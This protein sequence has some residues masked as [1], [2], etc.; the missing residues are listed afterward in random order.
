VGANWLIEQALKEPGGIW[1]VIAPTFRDVRATCFE[2]PSG[3]RKQLQPGE[4]VQWRRN[5]LRLDLVNGSI[6]YGFSADQPERLR[7]TNLSGCWSDEL[8][9]WRY[10]ETWY[11]GL[12]PALRIGKKPRVVITTTPRPTRLIKDLTSRRD[13]TVH[14]TQAATWE[15]A[16]NLSETALSEMRAR[17]EGT[18][19]GRQELE[20]QLLEDLE[21]ALWNRADIDAARIREDQVPDL[22]RIV[23]AIDPAVTNN[24]DSDETGIVVAGDDGNGH[25]YI[26]ADLSMMGTPE[27]CMKTAVAAYHRY[28]A[29]CVVAEVN[30]GGD[31]LGAVLRAADPNVPYHTVRASRGKAIRA[32]PVSALAEQHR[33][34]HVGLFPEL[35]DQMCSLTPG[36]SNGPDD[37][38]DACLAR[39]TLVLTERGNIPI[40]DVRVDDLAWTRMGWK[41]V[42][43]T[44]CTQRDARVMTA[45]LSD[46]SML[47]GTPDHQIWTERGWTRM[48]ALVCGDT[49]SAWTNHQQQSSTG[50]SSIGDI[51]IARNEGIESTTSDAHRQVSP[52]SIVTYGNMSMAGTSQRGTTSTIRTRIRST[53]NRTISFSSHPLNTPTSIQESDQILPSIWLPYV[54]SPQNGIAPKQGVHGIRT[55]ASGCGKTENQSISSSV[56][57]AEKSP[58]VT[59]QILASALGNAAGEKPTANTDLKYRSSALYVDANSGRTSIAQNPKRAHTTVVHSYVNSEKHDVYDL[60]I[61]DVHEFIAN[62]VVVHNCV[63]AV[64]ELRGLSTASW[65][66]A[67]GIQRCEQCN[68]PFSAQASQCKHCGA[69]ATLPPSKEKEEE[70][71]LPGSWAAI[72]AM[73][74][75]DKGHAYRGEQD[76]CPRCVSD[77][78]SY[79]R[80]IGS[81]VR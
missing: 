25:G 54:P 38:V 51:Q 53:T 15:N 76:T 22:V 60:T 14:I 9:S 2:G 63:W 32:E 57:H 34:H 6:I 12:I 69:E 47:T 16:K 27:K 43:A 18:R 74:R 61:E 78:F 59:F 19:L 66:Q 58:G 5:E 39:G 55:T 41:A 3:I 23:V 81:P 40:E 8:S 24:D 50:D 4:E 30:N 67:Y 56:S 52:R 71:P 44:R 28:A 45:V 29:D 33:L 13:G 42:T 46:G 20:G 49:L 75:C 36:I 10:P 1:A 72:Y 17:Y 65:L 7:G 64:M 37:R 79:L 26:L 80:S 21:G 77:T 62:G 48:D 70:S 35:E 31:Y 73:K 11:E 68:K